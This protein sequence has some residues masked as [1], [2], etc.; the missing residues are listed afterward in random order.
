M[1]AA[2]CCRTLTLLSASA[3]LQAIPDS[4]LLSFALADRLE[5]DGKTDEARHVL[6]ALIEKTRSNLAYCQRLRFARRAE[7]VSAARAVFKRAR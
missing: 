2:T 6:E 1:R 4:G 5:M 7:G 3:S